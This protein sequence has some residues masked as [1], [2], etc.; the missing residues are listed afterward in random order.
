MPDDTHNEQIHALLKK[1]IPHHL[2]QEDAE[3]ALA[4]LKCLQFDKQAN[5]VLIS[6]PHALYE[7]YYRKFFQNTF[8]ALLKTLFLPSI[9]I[10]YKNAALKSAQPVPRED[11][12]PFDRFICGKKNGQALEAAKYFCEPE[13]A[14]MLLHLTGPASAG[15]TH[16]LDSMANAIQVS[17][18]ET[19]VYR[20]NACDLEDAILPEASSGKSFALLLDDIHD[21]A[22]HDRAQKRLANIID[23]AM[24]SPHWT[25]VAIASSR[26]VNHILH[27]RL[28]V[29]L[30]RSLTV[31][32]FQADLTMRLQYAERESH[33]LSLSKQQI[34]RLARNCQRFTEIDGILQKMRFYGK[35]TG[36]PPVVEEME[37]L[38]AP[39]EAI[40]GWQKIVERVAKKTGL[41]TA[42]I[43]GQSRRKDIVLARQISMFLCRE[44]LGLSYPEIG[45]LFGGKDH[46]TV[47]HGINKIQQSRAD[48]SSLHMILTEL[49]NGLS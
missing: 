13:P 36:K 44:H 42:E 9:V 34:M 16:L 6:L 2:A 31:E 23:A 39:A 30:E 38:L 29:R 47:I 21:L 18:P 11:P 40:G 48:N 3:K 15:K 25:R 26:P 49:E 35:M 33:D 37:K 28:L 43:L 46:A 14:Q 5:Q 45:R 12:R 19:A 24:S 7:E 10:I 20:M 22:G 17:R 41:K 32:L 27:E 4:C 1:A 8:E